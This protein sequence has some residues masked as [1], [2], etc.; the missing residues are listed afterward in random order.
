M[1]AIRLKTIVMTVSFIILSSSALFA[2]SQEPQPISFS[3]LNSPDKEENS[4]LSGECT[5]NTASHEIECK[6]WQIRVRLALDPDDL[7]QEIQKAKRRLKEEMKEFDENI[8]ELCDD[9]RKH[10]AEWKQDLE[11]TD[12]MTS[13]EIKQM[14]D[15]VNF[16][17][18]PTY[19]KLERLMIR[20]IEV[21]TRTCKVS[22]DPEGWTAKFTKVAK[23]KWVS[24]E[25][26]TGLCNAVILMELEHEP[27]Y[28]NLWTYTRTRTYADQKSELCKG[29]EV[30]TPLTYSWKEKAIELNCQFIR[31]G[32]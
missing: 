22:A 3:Y 8:K 20:D 9:I 23:N 2:Q 1:R 6:F 19:E 26:P 29:L 32:F 31:Y 17:D 15:M 11:T 30:G 21:L 13:F 27:N 24:S 5:G 16:C 12:R 18:K 10:S 14:K 28:S 4:A 7:P 25:G